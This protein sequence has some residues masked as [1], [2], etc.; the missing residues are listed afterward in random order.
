MTVTPTKVSGSRG[1]ICL[2][3]SGRGRSLPASGKVPETAVLISLTDFVAGTSAYGS[4]EV[5]TRR[6][7]HISE[8]LFRK[9]VP[10]GASPWPVR[11]PVA[12][13]AARIS[14][15]DT[16]KDGARH[17][18]LRGRRLGASCRSD[19]RHFRQEAVAPGAEEPLAPLVSKG[20]RATGHGASVIFQIPPQPTNRA[21]L[22]E[23]AHR[24][25]NC[26]GF[27]AQ[28]FPLLFDC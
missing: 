22:R 21:N 26:A 7:F 20:D 6:P 12:L 18:P 2:W 14:S 19:S 24:I 1:P 11:H 4:L 13:A 25:L 10:A 17:R 16:A 28:K 8:N 27:P 3:W 9:E 5:K 15:G 23:L